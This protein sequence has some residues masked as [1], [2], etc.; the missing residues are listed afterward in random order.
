MESNAAAFVGHYDYL[1]VA[2]SVVIAILSAYA[3]LDLAGRVTNARGRARFAWLVGGAVA[4]GNGIWSMHYIGMLAF[5]LP[6]PSLYDWPTVLASLGVAVLASGIGLYVVSR[7]TMGTPAVIVGSIF[8]G[9]GIAGMHYLGM[10]AMRLPAMC[11]YSA[12]LVVLSVLL[13][14]AISLVALLRTFALRNNLT[15]WSYGKAANAIILGAAIPTMHYVGMAAV[16]F[17]PAALPPS[18]LHHAIGISGLGIAAIT[19]VCIAMLCLVYLTSIADRSFSRQALELEG[20]EHRYRRIIEST[21]DA[22]LGID[23]DGLVTDWNARAEA[24]FGWTPVE[25][26]GKSADEIFQW[27]T[28]AAPYTRLSSA[29]ASGDGASLIDRIEASGRHRDGT[30]FPVEIALSSLHWAQQNLLFAFV[31]DVTKRKAEEMEREEARAA[32]E[33]GSRAKGEFLANMSHEIR[34]PLNGVIGMTDLVLETELTAEQRE[35]L[36]TARFSAEALLNVINDILD[37]S[38][39]EA[40]KIDLDNV[41]FNLCES[42]EATLKTLALKADEKGLELLCDVAPKT[43]EMVVGDSGRLR[44]VITN[45]VGNAIKFTNEGEVELRVEPR[46]SEDGA[47]ALHFLVSDTGI[48]ISQEKL[49]TI[50][51]SFAQADTS[52]TRKYGGTGLGLTI[53]KRLA[54]LMGGRIWVESQ[55]GKGSQFHFTARFETAAPAVPIDGIAPGGLVGVRVLVIDD[56]RTNRRILEGLLTNWGMVPTAVS[57][58][59]QALSALAAANLQRPYDLILTDMHMPEM[60]GFGVVEAIR[61][62]G[63]APASTIMMLTSA[64]HRGDAVRCRELGIAAYLLKPVRQAELRQAIERVLGARSADAVPQ[65]V[66]R[67]SLRDEQ[68]PSARLRVLLAED[69]DVNRKLAVRLIE[70]RG[71]RVTA[72][73]NG[74]EALR[75]LE[76]DVYDL[77]LMDVQM[78]EMD[79]I[80]ATQAIRKKEAATKGHQTIVAMTALVMSGDRERCLSAGMD[81][82]LAKPIRGGELDDILDRYGRGRHHEAARQPSPSSSG[83]FAV[84]PASQEPCRDAIDVDELMERLEGDRAFLATLAEAFRDDRQAQIHMIADAIERRDAQAVRRTSHALKGAL[85]NLAATRA[86]GIAFRLE[87]MG[88]ANDLDGASTALRQLDEELDQVMGSL[89]A[90]CPEAVR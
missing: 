34:T 22:F 84:S 42:I 75:A 55:P 76:S 36:E 73:L 40:G 10:E 83:E 2:L 20:R 54:E 80:E 6:V 49:D 37:F 78:P 39:I 70:K 16:S 19:A 88:T 26:I 32:A 11:M 51:E 30:V 33:A 69:N 43:P 5:R 60:D 9:L 82:Y 65:M 50:F 7:K 90:L 14:I 44:Q 67:D 4:M 8:M 57:S 58:G 27:N 46:R 87:Q 17:H 71:H 77:V 18:S 24:M 56:N 45:L 81:D 66:T 85:A 68:S 29:A 86:A 41:P 12:R 15:S 48:G 79:G 31:H 63:G 52:T 13:A 62:R 59:Q 89:E 72:V 35:Y 28:G 64:G 53:S 61:Q 74:Q 3:A 25:A 23:Q 1:L 21:F 38:K 47:S